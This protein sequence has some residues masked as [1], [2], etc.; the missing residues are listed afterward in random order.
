MKG[1]PTQYITKRQ[2]FYGR[3]FQVT[4]DVLIPRPETELLVETVLKLRAQRQRRCDRYRN[5]LRA[6]SR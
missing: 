4:R 6:P 1:K 2:E 5:R 3:E